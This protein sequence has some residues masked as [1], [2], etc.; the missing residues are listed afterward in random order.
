MAQRKNPAV[1]GSS[2]EF[3]LSEVQSELDSGFKRL[4]RIPDSHVMDKIQYFKSLA[5]DDKRAFLDCCA[6][7][8]SAHY[9]FVVGMNRLSLTDHPFFAKWNQG[10]RWG[11][12]FSSPKSVPL[13][14]AMVQQYKIDQHNGVR[15]H[16]TKEQFEEAAAVRSVKAPELRKR[17]RMALKPFG[18]F[19][20]DT[21]NQYWCKLGKRK[22]IVHLDFGGRTAQLRYSVARPEFKGVHPLS[23]FRLERALGFGLGHWN[24]IVEENVDDTFAL[25]AEVV[26]YSFDLPDRIRAAVRV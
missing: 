14:R 2:R 21:L 11:R 25:F 18:H 9:G 8:A 3:F 23:Q 10:P 1:L 4:T 6:Y 20:T 16:I 24:Y 15:S 22:F 19:E 26:Q 13:L 12:D 17:V 7:W 5:P